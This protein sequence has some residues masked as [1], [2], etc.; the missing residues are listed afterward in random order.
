MSN[1]AAVA[2]AL[3][4]DEGTAG[5]GPVDGTGREGIDRPRGTRRESYTDE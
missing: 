4:D 5:R 3:V 2:A 1:T